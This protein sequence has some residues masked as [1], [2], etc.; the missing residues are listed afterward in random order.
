MMESAQIHELTL[1]LQTDT[2]TDIASSNNKP[3]AHARTSIHQFEN[4]W[5]DNPG[6]VEELLSRELFELSLE[7]RNVF[8]D[9]IHGVCCIAPEE[10]PELLQISLRELANEL[11]NSIPLDQKRAYLQTKKLKESYVNKDAFR[12]RFLRC[13]LFNVPKAAVRMALFLDLLL[14][15]FGSFALHRPIKLSDFN[16]RELSEFRKGRLQLLPHRDR[17][18]AGSGRRIICFFPDKEWEL[19]SPIT[20]HKIVV[21]QTF[22]AGYD[23]DTQ[24]KGIVFLVWFDSKLEP[25]WKPAF[26]TKI[27]QMPS[28]RISALHICTPD[29]PFYRARRSLLIMKAGNHRSR[30]RVHI[31]ES[32]E[33]RY[34]LQGFGFPSNK[35]PITY[36]GSIKTVDLKKWMRLRRLQE[37]EHLNRNIASNTKNNHITSS[38][39]G[40]GSNMEMIDSPYLSDMIFRKGKS[41]MAHP[42][43]A[44]LR[45]LI[46]SKIESGAFENSKLKTR[47]FINEIIEE[48]KQRGNSSGTGGGANNRNANGT[49]SPPIRL[50]IWDDTNVGNCWR[51]I[52]DDDAVYQ[53]IRHIVKDLQN[54]VQEENSTRCKIQTMINQSG[55]TSIFQSQ[56]GG[57][58]LPFGFASSS[59]STKKQRL[60]NGFDEQGELGYDMS[61]CFGM[62]G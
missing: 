13:E 50:L 61:E 17:G 51:E 33:L 8:Q 36:S 11:E 48:M 19:I 4:D 56:D 62:R 37:D 49:N 29:T 60:N 31:G 43:N 24:R 57:T 42:G 2:A 26:N 15:I 53:K 30:L 18:G 5:K 40:N 54:I 58:N 34:I 55:G 1:R 21:Y 38:N 59:R 28:V 47:K 46:K 44:T 39:N 52:V 6:Q 45:R 27:N 3:P 25:S 20:R 9:E 35:I 32:M 41:T 7:N 16:K 10:T 22:V 14:D 23:I 12:L